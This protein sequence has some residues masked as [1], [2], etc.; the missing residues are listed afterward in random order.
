MMQNIFVE[1]NRKI[2][3][4]TVVYE[5]VL[6]ATVNIGLFTIKCYCV[7]YTDVIKRRGVGCRHRGSTE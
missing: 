2:E 7:L 1:Q 5:Y 3:A 4:C 6:Y